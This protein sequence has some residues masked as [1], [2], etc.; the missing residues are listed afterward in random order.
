MSHSREVDQKHED[1]IWFIVVDA[2]IDTLRPLALRKDFAKAFFE[3]R[4]YAFIEAL[5]K[6]HR[7]GFQKLFDHLLRGSSKTASHHSNL[8][9]SDLRDV[10]KKMFDDQHLE[11]LVLQN[12]NNSIKKVNSE[13]FQQ[14]SMQTR[15]GILCRQRI[16]GVCKHLVDNPFEEEEDLFQSYSEA[17]DEEQFQFGEDDPQEEE[18]GGSAPPKIKVFACRHAFHIRCLRGYY[19]RKWGGTQTGREEIERMFKQAQERLRCVTCNLKNIEVDSEKTGNKR[20]GVNTGRPLTVAPQQM[21]KAVPLQQQD[22]GE[23]SA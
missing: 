1:A 8:H 10:I 22:E 17:M 21:E 5:V 23:A 6:V 18:A 20:A 11:T 16:C 19:L 15:C 14:F 4:F 2:L 3:D 7:D 12:A 9:F 13:S